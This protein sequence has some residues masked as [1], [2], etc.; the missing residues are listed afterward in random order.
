VER[1]IRLQPQVRVIFHDVYVPPQQLIHIAGVAVT[2]P[3][4]T[5]VDLALGLHRDPSLLEWLRL[6]AH[7]APRAT[8]HAIAHAEALTR[9]PGTKR[10]IHTLRRLR[11][12][13]D[14]VTR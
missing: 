7:M 3:M 11:D 10:A 8:D 4:R 6:L 13:Q 12:R 2:D 14:D 9:V 1:R 5:M